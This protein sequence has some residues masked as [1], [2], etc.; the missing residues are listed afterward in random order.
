MELSAEPKRVMIFLAP[1][2]KN[3]Q[4][5]TSMNLTMS[6]LPTHTFQRDA[7]FLGEHMYSGIRSAHKLDKLSRKLAY[8]HNLSNSL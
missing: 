7:I 3:I 6:D 4:Q 8:E 2:A 5:L 1:D